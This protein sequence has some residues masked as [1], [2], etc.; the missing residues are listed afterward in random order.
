[1]NISAKTMVWLL[2][3]F[4]FWTSNWTPKAGPGDI[5]DGPDMLTELPFGKRERRRSK[6]DTRF[7]LLR[8]LL[9]FLFF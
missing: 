9:M 2:G 7:N 8:P 6:A 3:L 4:S 5:Q 1:M